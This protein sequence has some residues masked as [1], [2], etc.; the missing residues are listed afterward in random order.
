MLFWV[1]AGAKMPSNWGRW[2]RPDAH[3]GSAGRGADRQGV[4]RV[5]HGVGGRAVPRGGLRG[6]GC[7]SSG[8]RGVLAAARGARGGGPTAGL[9]DAGLDQP[10]RRRCR[11]HSHGHDH[12]GDAEPAVRP[13]RG[14]GLGPLDRRELVRIGVGGV[15]VGEELPLGGRGARVD[16]GSPPLGGRGGGDARDHSSDRICQ[17]W[18]FLHA[19]GRFW[20]SHLKCLGQLCVFVEGNVT[21]RAPPLGGNSVKRP[22]PTWLGGAG[23]P[24]PTG[25]RESRGSPVSPGAGHG[26]LRVVVVTSGPPQTEGYLVG[27]GRAVG[28]E[29]GVLAQGL[30]GRQQPLEAG[31]ALEASFLICCT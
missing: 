26:T 18:V 31:G 5:R 19:H 12:H 16:R 22:A 30:E 27:D 15:G 7:G 4:D 24:A 11:Q 8:A 3:P 20:P 21:S 1:L 13:V 6:D 25:P 9:E 28:L 17:P 23:P 10:E 2:P 14:P 29:L